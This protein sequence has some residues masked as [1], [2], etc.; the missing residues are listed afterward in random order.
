MYQL[1]NYCI[2]SF[3]ACGL[4]YIIVKYS[5]LTHVVVL[6][7]ALYCVC[8]HAY[9]EPALIYDWENWTKLR[10]TIEYW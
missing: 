10:K 6:C 5:L 3:M 8:R 9:N 7:T 1:L 2:A 4:K